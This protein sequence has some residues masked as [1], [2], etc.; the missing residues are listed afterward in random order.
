MNLDNETTNIRMTAGRTTGV[1]A[2]ARLPRATIR[3]A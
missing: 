1:G 2:S 3:P